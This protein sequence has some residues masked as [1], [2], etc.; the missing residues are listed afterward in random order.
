MRAWPHPHGP[1][2][3]ERAALLPLADA[4]LA[5]QLTAVVALYRL[6]WNLETDAADQL[7]LQ[8]ALHHAIGDAGKIVTTLIEIL[9]CLGGD[10]AGNRVLHLITLGLLRV[11]LLT[12]RLVADAN[13]VGGTAQRRWHL[14][15]LLWSHLRRIDRGLRPRAELVGCLDLPFD[16]LDAAEPLLGGVDG[17]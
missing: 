2:T 3:L 17:R 4:V 16:G 12:L 7:V 1:R 11:L 15:L 6:V 8:L 5:E 13:P 9:R 14:L 10:A